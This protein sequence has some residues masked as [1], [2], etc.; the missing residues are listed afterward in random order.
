MKKLS[1][2]VS[3][4]NEEQGLNEFYK[5]TSGILDALSGYETE[6]CFVNDGSTDR[7]WQVIESLQEENPDVVSNG[8]TIKAEYVSV[9]EKENRSVIKVD[10]TL[11]AD[12]E[13][14]VISIPIPAG[15]SYDENSYS[16]TRGESHRE[17]YKDR[18]NIF[19]ER[20]GEGSHHFEVPLNERYPGVYTINPSEV[21]LIY[22]PAFNA[23]YKKT[24][25]RL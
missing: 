21:H 9:N 13:Y 22:F 5:V 16:Y 18:V 1:L 4:Y 17:E 10:V 3:V 23:N 7:S 19:C 12:A 24:K 11:E 15:C 6:I 14:L 25:V 8:M 20:I 2:I